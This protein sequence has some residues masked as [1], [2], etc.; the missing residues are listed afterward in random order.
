MAISYINNMQT[1]PIEKVSRKTLKK[2]DRD[3]PVPF[4]LALHDDKK[5]LLC[6]KVIRVV[7]GK[8]LV[9]FGRWDD[10]PIVAKLFFEWSKAKKHLE[11]DI[12]GIEALIAANVPTPKL[13]FQGRDK[14]KRIYVLIFERIMDSCNLDLLWEEKTDVAELTPLMRAVTIELATQHV[15]GIVQRDLHL[16]NFLVTSKMIYTLDGGSI[17]TIDGPLSKKDS[18][19][20]LGLFFAQL[21]AGTNTLQNELFDLYAQSRGWIVRPNDLELLQQSITKWTTQRWLRY[22]KKIM[23][24]C[25]AFERKQNLSTLS[26]S[27]R[28]YDSVEFKEL[29]SNPDA[30]F[31]KSNTTILKAGRSSSVAKI[32]LNNHTLVIKR[33]NIKGFSHWLRRC[34]RPTRAARSWC[35]AHH[36]K[37]MNVATAKPVAFIEKSFLGLRH[38]SYF[39]MEYVD[40]NHA[41][42]Y[43][44]SYRS[45]DA[46]FMQVAQRI[47]AI[48]YQLAEL[49]ITHGDLKM[50]N[51]L[52]AH[53]KPILIDLDGMH[54]HQKQAAFKR[55]FKKEINR[56]MKNWESFPS[57]QEM[58][59]QLI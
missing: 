58:F 16:K 28:Q 35:L 14:S 42:D 44:T 15:L 21:G 55:A 32:K 45:D 34:L 41:G 22:E 38:K 56:F 3:I 54:E 43:F 48:I 39:I 17:E 47:L 53:E 6:E 31:T 8:R 51:I 26:L 12:T 23:R 20:H 19:E 57:V 29:L 5:V 49:K 27:D 52:I 37:L 30:F 1:K 2:A 59:R 13:F 25:S 10:K 7:P 50:T 4:E 11:R 36:L 33:Y 9:A 18:L 46:R 24:D 40:G